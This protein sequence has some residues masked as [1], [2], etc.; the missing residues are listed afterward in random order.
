MLSDEHWSKLRTNMRQQRIYD[1]S[2]LRQMV[3]GMLY[4]MRV[5]SPWRDLPEE[6]GC[7]ISIYQKFNRW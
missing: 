7:W 1:K 2:N 6:F 4:R 3:E 5:G